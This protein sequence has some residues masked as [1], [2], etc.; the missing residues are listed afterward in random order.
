MSSLGVEIIL[1][2]DGSHTL[3]V[4]SLNETYHSTHGAIQESKHVF[5]KNGLEFL[6]DSAQMDKVAI[7]EIGFGTGLNTLLTYEFSAM[8]PEI[9]IEYTSLE[10][11]PLSEEIIQG[12]NYH[13]Q[14][15]SSALGWQKIHAADW[16]VPTLISNNY[17]ILK[18]PNT[19]Q[20]FTPDHSFDLIYFDAFAPGKQPEVWDKTIFEKLFHIMNQGAVLTTYCAQGK[21]KRN[22]KS[23]G[24][25]VES[26]PGPPGKMQIVRASKA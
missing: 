22:L 6:T 24:F 10:P 16:G 13:K 7:L 19:V 12:L 2:E 18:L 1:T 4:P 14:E 26:L 8:N 11:F 3:F 20:D 25:K 5:I 9:K 15:D 21:F 17:K 23:I